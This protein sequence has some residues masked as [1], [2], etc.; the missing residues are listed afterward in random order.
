M[1]F[2]SG[3]LVNRRAYR[4]FNVID[5]CARDALAIE[6]DF[7]LTGERVVRVLQKQREGHGKP[8]AMRSDNGPAFR[9]HVVQAWAKSDDIEWQFTEPGCPAQNAYIKR[10]N[11]TFP[12]EVLDAYQFENLDQ[13][14]AID[15]QWIPVYNEQRTHSAIGHLPPMSS[16]DKGSYQSLH[17][18]VV[19]GEGY[20]PGAFVCV[21]GFSELVRVLLHNA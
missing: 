10:F 21:E 19:S 11:G 2:M 16:N 6:I 3:T 12:A 4:T 20:G 15:E 14:R 9:S 5:D 7:S 8:D 17:F 18:R 13:V 1:D